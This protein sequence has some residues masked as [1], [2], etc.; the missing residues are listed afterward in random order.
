M[1]ILD[2][3]V[4]WIAEQ[5]MYGL[6]LINTS[7]LGALGCDMSAFLRYFPAAET[8]YHIFV[9]LAIGM[10]LLNLIWQL[11]LTALPL[12]IIALVGINGESLS[13]FIFLVLKYLHNRRV[14]TRNEEEQGKRKKRK[15]RKA[16]GGDA[17][18]KYINPVAEY[19]PGEKIENGI[20]YTRDHRYLK[21]VEVVPINFLLRSAR[22]QRNIIYSFISFLKISPVKMQIKVIAKR[23]DLNRHREIVQ[24]EMAQETDENC[25]L[26]Q[27]DY[28]TLIDRIGAREA[29]TRRFFMVFEYEAWAG[30]K[31]G[32]EEE[33]AIAF[34]QTAARTA[35]NYLKQC[36]NEVLIPENDDEFT[37][38]TLYH[39]LCRNGTMSLPDRVR[40]IIA[41]YREHFE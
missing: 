18:P 20:I 6:D 16:K 32:N 41:Q 11:C 4:E 30:R 31:R 23:A 38:D 8:M 36:G 15:K 19:L 17:A 7:V 2:G 22:E 33:E 35:V 24:Q 5:V 1:G 9:A 12:G 3:I 10:I 39:L 40:Q 26:L 27:Q 37:V 14:I 29:T 13:S 25:R 28:L 21:I 34:L